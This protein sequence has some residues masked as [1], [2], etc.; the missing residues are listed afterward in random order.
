LA[1]ITAQAR[2]T[3]PP[4]QFASFERIRDNYV[5]GR[6]ATNTPQGQFNRL[7]PGDEL[8][9][10]DS[11]LG[12][13]A[14]GLAKDPSHFNKELGHRVEDLQGAFRG[15]ID[16]VNAPNAWS[17]GAQHVQDLNNAN[18][19]YARW[20][21]VRDAAANANNG[22]YSPAQ[23]AQSVVR[24]AGTKN[25][26][27]R[28]DALMQDLADAGRAVLPQS[29]PN[30]GTTDRRNLTELALALFGGHAAGV[31]P[32]VLAGGLGGRGALHRAWPS[33]FPAYCSG[34]SGDAANA[35]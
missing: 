21:R 22:V 18:A 12:S 23:F 16:R 6:F 2:Q 20:V 31:G 34:L 10:I 35:G 15:M 30:S 17:N 28:G 24:N 4:D 3:L 9:G 26:A 29:V 27:A 13:Q 25:Q 5:V 8:K 32:G 19:A 7:I 1:R 14:R 33:R 11:E